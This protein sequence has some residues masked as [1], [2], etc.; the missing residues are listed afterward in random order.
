MSGI[1]NVKLSSILYLVILLTLYV[2]QP[3]SHSWGT[4]G[5]WF[6]KLSG[7]WNIW[8]HC[9]ICTDHIGN[10][11][12]KIFFNGKLASSQL[13]PEDLSILVSNHQLNYRIRK[14]IFF[15]H[16]LHPFQKEERQLVCQK[17]NQSLSQKGRNLY[18]L[19]QK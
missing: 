4:W 14:D 9:I 3:I 8:S 5:A 6:E 10:T 12:E 7:Y 1:I 18:H 17:K 2:Y 13:E 16:Q 11:Q 19:T 15:I